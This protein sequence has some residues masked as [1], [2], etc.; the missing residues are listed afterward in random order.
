MLPNMTLV[1]DQSEALQLTPKA[2]LFRSQ[3]GGKGLPLTRWCLGILDGGPG[4]ATIG[5]VTIR[6]VAV[7]FDNTQRQLTFRPVHSCAD[8][9][10]SVLASEEG[11]DMGSGR[12]DGTA[13]VRTQQECCGLSSVALQ[14]TMA[15]AASR[16]S[17]AS[18]SFLWIPQR[19]A[20][21]EMTA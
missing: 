11:T 3:R 8:F 18:Q 12:K 15:R 5:A 6:D 1:L 4:T 2:Y 13:V 19:Q 14:C 10:A 9:S 17:Q 21:G 16:A 20:P 7:T